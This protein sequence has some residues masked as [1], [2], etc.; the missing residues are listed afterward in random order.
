MHCFLCRRDEGALLP[1]I[2]I[3]D[4]ISCNILARRRCK[5]NNNL[6]AILLALHS[7]QIGHSV[8]YNA[9]LFRYI[10]VIDRIIAAVV[11]GLHTIG[12]RSIRFYNMTEFVPK[13][14]IPVEFPRSLPVQVSEPNLIAAQIGHIC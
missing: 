7:S 5:G 4:D 13:D 2:T 6:A 12:I 3:F 1:I 11:E 10:G 9:N 8:R 14:R